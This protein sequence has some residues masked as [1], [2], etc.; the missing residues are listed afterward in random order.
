MTRTT[1]AR[2]VSVEAVLPELAARRGRT[3]RLHP[4]RGRP[5]VR[6][7]HVGGPMLWPEGEAWPVCDEPHVRETEGYAPDEIRS[8]RAAGVHPPSRPWPRTTPPGPSPY[9]ALAQLFRRDVPGLA[10]GPGGADLVQLFRCPFA[11]GPHHERRYFLRWRRA[12][13]ADRAGRTLAVPPEVPM[14]R[15]EH[16]LPEPCVLHPEEVDTYPWAEG[17]AL[18]AELIARID[19]WDE[20]QEAAHGTDAL[21]YQ[22]DLS[23][24]PGWRVGGFPS[25]ASTGPMAVDC[26][27]CTTPMRLL[28][29]AEGYETDGPAHSWVPL[30]DRDPFLRGWA[31]IRDAPAVVQPTRLRF[32]RDRDMHVFVCPAEG[33]HPP[34]W[35]LA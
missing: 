28:L 2:P 33:G 13:E 7:S 9:V 18:P 34:R 16:D 35:V 29:T 17:D 26:A 25:W 21:S 23:I 22:Y 19:A 15:W 1:P 31:S 3:T 32:G 5:G 30:E 8:A 14:L 27:S 20:A 24:P 11:H 4:R 6:D 10:S 12:E